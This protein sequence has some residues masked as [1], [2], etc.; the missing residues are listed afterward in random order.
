MD[1]D[2]GNSGV[3]VKEGPWEYP[4]ERTRKQGP[5]SESAGGTVGPW[6]SS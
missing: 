6:K 3:E 1:W 4:G 2:H 5:W